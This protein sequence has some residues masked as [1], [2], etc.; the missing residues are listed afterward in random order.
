MLPYFKQSGTFTSNESKTH[1][2]QNLYCYYVLLYYYYYYY[3]VLLYDLLCQ[4]VV[5]PGQETILKYPAAAYS[6]DMICSTP[7]GHSHP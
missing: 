6:A 5:D 4:A 7:G 2:Y 3:Y 1:M